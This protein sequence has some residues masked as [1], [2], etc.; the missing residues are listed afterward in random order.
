MLVYYILKFCR[1]T[2]SENRDVMNIRLLCGG[3]T[4]IS[5]GHQL[6]VYLLV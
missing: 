3:V 4:F 6:D 5:V 2:L 1:H